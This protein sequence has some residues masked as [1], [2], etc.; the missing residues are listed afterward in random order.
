[1]NQLAI[2]IPYYK[3]DFFEET[4]KSVASQSNRNFTL[5]IGND[6]SPNNPVVLIQKYFKDHEY[7]YY[8]YSKNIGASN[9]ALQW[10]RILENVHEEWFHILGDDD[11]ISENFVQE[12]YTNLDDI[13]KQ[14][15]NVVK[16]SQALIDERRNVITEFTQYKTIENSVSLWQKKFHLNHR[17]SLSEHIFRKKS[18][19]IFRFKEF[20]L[21]WHT[22]DLAVLEYSYF[23]NIFFI[24]NATVLVRVSSLSISGDTENDSYNE[25]KIEA[26][27]QFIGF[28]INNYYSQLGRD[29]LQLMIKTQIEFCWI[30][31]KKLNINL[32]K[33]YYYL[34]SYKQILGIPRKSL[35]LLTNRKPYLTFKH[36]SKLIEKTYNYLHYFLS[37]KLNKNL[38]KQRQNPKSIPVIIINYNQLYYL[39]ILV[40]F[41]QERKFENI[42]IVDNN[43]DYP[44]LLEYYKSIKEFITIE[45]MS[46]NLGHLVFFENKDLQKKYGNGYFVLTDPDIVPNSN[47]PEDFL[48][49]MIAILDDYF[50]TTTKVGFALD[51]ETIPDTFPLKQKVLK[52]EKKFWK[53][54]LKDNLYRAN[55]DTTFALYKPYYPKHYKDLPFFQ[56]VRV[57]DQYTA[58]HGGWYID[59]LQYS[60]ENLHY[61]NSVDKSSSWKLDNHGKHDNKVTAV[62]KN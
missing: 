38:K 33:L 23:K 59:P 43:S 62:Y 4:L 36:Y 34:K 55:I 11:I 45:T 16:F 10:Q 21:A 50:S 48:G 37:I 17:S 9:L 1:M 19:D 24:N 39:K 57:A 29:V 8:E 25:K 47:L 31:K 15:I 5:Y 44:P 58:I 6:A 18:F 13:E 28:V 49:Q 61:I 51:L 52:W 3:I 46:S 2:I 41:L 20:P 26:K 22:D 56:G 42:I 7:K 30:Y 32:F 40:N 53:N 27:Y 12:F 54:K 14:N 60:E 35:L